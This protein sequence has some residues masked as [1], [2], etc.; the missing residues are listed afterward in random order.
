MIAH[1]AEELKIIRHSVLLFVSAF[2]LVFGAMLLFTFQMIT[3]VGQ[4]FWFL[5]PGSP[6][7]ATQI[8]LAAKNFLVPAGIPIVALSPMASLAASITMAFL[9]SILLTFP[10]G[11]Y[12]IGRFFWP[13]L[14]KSERR[15]LARYML[16]ALVLFYGGCAF[17]YFVIIPQTF[18]LL[19]AFAAPLDVAPLFAL[20]DLVMSVFLLTLV[21]GCV[22]LLPIVM[23]ALSHI[24]LVERSFWRR[25]W[26]GAV[27]S[28]VIFAAVV[29]PDGSGVTA[30]F[31]SGPLI[32]LYMVGA[33]SAPYPH[34]RGK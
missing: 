32:A 3:V 19:Y 14:H 16:P 29:T 20:D 4:S 15:G 23:M 24:G 8:F 25:H 7:L 18:D 30:V 26:R 33:L 9:M 10:L 2:F 17:G 6:S 28:M 21:T 22:F 12:L 1:I 13:A 31:L 5:V 27:V 34:Q 11:L